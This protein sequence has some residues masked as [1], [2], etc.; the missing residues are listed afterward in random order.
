MESRKPRVNAKTLTDTAIAFM[1]IALIL[2]VLGFTVERGL[3]VLGIVM[4]AASVVVGLIGSVINAR[5]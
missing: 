4:F 2:F 1:V 3:L 5:R